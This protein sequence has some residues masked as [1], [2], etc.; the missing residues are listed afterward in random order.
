MVRDL[1]VLV[2]ALALVILAALV[3]SRCAPA[4]LDEP[5]PTIPPTTDCSVRT[6]SG[7]CPP[8][9]STE[10]LCTICARFAVTERDR[11]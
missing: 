1:V 2:G 10:A 7:F 3:L 11:E 9:L 6:P 4:W 8:P 5:P